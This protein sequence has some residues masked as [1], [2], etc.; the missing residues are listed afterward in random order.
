MARLEEEIM[1]DL[2]RRPSEP[3]P[4]TPWQAVYIEQHDDDTYH[5]CSLTNDDNCDGRPDGR[6]SIVQITGPLKDLLAVFGK[7]SRVFQGREIS[8]FVNG[9]KQ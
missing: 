9:V 8:I 1:R 5:C 2:A 7:T 6:I 3:P 4:P